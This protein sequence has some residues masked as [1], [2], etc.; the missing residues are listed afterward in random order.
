MIN[1]RGTLIFFVEHFELF[2][3]FQILSMFLL[4]IFNILSR[5]ILSIKYHITNLPLLNI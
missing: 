4:I 1:F 3:S 5:D 2:T